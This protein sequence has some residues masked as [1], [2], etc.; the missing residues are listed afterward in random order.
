M[1]IYEENVS[2]VEIVEPHAAQPPRRT[3]RLAIA[4]LICAIVICC[5]PLTSLAAIILGI[6]ALVAIR[7]HGLRGKVLAWIGIVLGVLLTIAGSL[8]IW[9]NISMGLSVITE[10][11][12]VLTKALHAG[13][14]GDI[15]AFRDEFEG[16]VDSADD[17]DITAFITELRTRYGEFD[18]AVFDMQRGEAEGQDETLEMGLRLVFETEDVEAWVVYRMGFVPW[19][20]T[21]EIRCIRVIDDKADNIVFPSGSQCDIEKQDDDG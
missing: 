10:A 3:S 9:F 16:K 6:M 18:K 13:Y 17:A 1:N 8:L 2:G 21:F 19:E 4:S 5:S 7:R 12:N 11:P 20:L 15:S 14:D